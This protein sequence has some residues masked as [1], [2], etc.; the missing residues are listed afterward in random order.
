LVQDLFHRH[1][2]ID[3]LWHF[4]HLHFLILIIL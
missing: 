3:M 1:V 4:L 2:P